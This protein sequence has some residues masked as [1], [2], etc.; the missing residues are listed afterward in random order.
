M[1]QRKPRSQP[2]STVQREVIAYAVAALPRAL[3]FAVPN[4][5]RRTPSGRAAN[6]VPGLMPGAPD[7]VICL[8]G[9][10]VLW[11]EVKASRGRLSDAQFMF[12]GKLHAL[13]HDYAVVRSLG[14]LRLTFDALGIATREVGQ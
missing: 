6:A 8:P 9:G 10:R 1:T 14:D 3:V 13:G 7:L 11:V 2:E 4:A 12:C 5:A